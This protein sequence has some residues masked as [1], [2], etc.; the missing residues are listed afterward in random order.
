MHFLYPSG[1][2]IPKF[3][4]NLLSKSIPFSWPKTNTDFLWNWANPARTDSSSE[5]LLSPDKFIKFVNRFSI[6]NFALGLS[7]CLATWVFCKAFKFLYESFS[8]LS[9]SSCILDILSVSTCDKP[10]L[11]KG[12]FNFSTS[13]SKAFISRSN[14]K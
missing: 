5:N 11:L 1:L 6:K 14:S 7:S 12:S 9:I 13:S 3:L 2:I 10:S 4:F 8:L